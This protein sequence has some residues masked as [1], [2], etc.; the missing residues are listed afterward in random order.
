MTREEELQQFAER[1]TK[2]LYLDKH[3]LIMMV[4]AGANWA[5]SHP[6]WIPVEEKKP[7][8][9][10]VVLIYSKGGDVCVTCYKNGAFMLRCKVLLMH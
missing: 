6:Q 10:Q 9:G 5:Y 7:E 2:G 8:E 1:E 4:K 3:N